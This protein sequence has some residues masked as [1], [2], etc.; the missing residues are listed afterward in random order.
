MAGFLAPSE[1]QLNKL[2]VLFFNLDVVKTDY[3]ERERC[4]SILFLSDQ[5]NVK[6]HIKGMENI[7]EET[8]KG[9]PTIANTLFMLMVLT[10]IRFGFRVAPLFQ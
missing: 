5:I 9:T 8:E 7:Q 1:S 10:P 3:P 6:C 4:S 2:L